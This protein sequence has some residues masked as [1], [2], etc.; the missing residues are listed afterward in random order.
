MQTQATRWL[1][2]PPTF[3]LAL[4]KQDLNFIRGQHWQD[5][6][7]QQAH[8]GKWSCLP[9]RSANGEVNNIAATADHFLD[10]PFLQACPYF[11]LVLNSFACEKIAVRLMSLA[12]GAR[13]L[14]HRDAGGGFEDGV[15]RLHIPI[16]TAPEVV[17]T[18]DGECVHFRAGQTWYMNAN[19]LHAVE[20]NSPL[21]RIHL[22]IDCVPNPWL[23][24][25]FAQAGW[26]ANSPPKYGDPT[27]NDE[28]VQSVIATLQQN[29]SP[30][31]QQMAQMLAARANLAP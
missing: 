7:N 28:N 5:H 24:E 23:Q 26:I 4:L 30:A 31:A 1:Q 11:Q 17:F 29:P 9:L 10:T 20:N 27:I 2:L 22:V 8:Q 13:I 6:Y 15:A 14:P 12:A 16:I 18:I 3:D 21:E 19:C 25:L